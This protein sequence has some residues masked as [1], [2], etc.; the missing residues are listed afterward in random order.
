MRRPVHI[1]LGRGEDPADSRSAPGPASVPTESHVALDQLLAV[2]ELFAIAQNLTIVQE[3]EIKSL[4]SW[5]HDWQL[6]EAAG[7]QP[8]VL[9]FI[10][11]CACE[12][13]CRSSGDIPMTAFAVRVASLRIH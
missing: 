11:E 12:C 1:S 10:R 6:Q 3:D 2:A 5:I 13:L 8:A 4:T 9:Q 7:L